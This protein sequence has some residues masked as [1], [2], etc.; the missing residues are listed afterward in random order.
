MRIGIDIDGV[1]TNIEQFIIDYLTRY[2]VLHHI[3]Y[4]IGEANYEED[5]AFGIS[6]EIKDHFWE[7]YLE[8]YAIHE[9]ARA[10]SSEVIQKLHE[11][12]NEIY[13][14]TARSLS[15]R[16][17]SIGKHMRNLVKEWLKRNN[18][19]YDQLIF[20]KASDEN[21]LDE[22]LEYKID[23][24]IEDN[25]SNIEN[26]SKYIPIICYDADY[27]RHCNGLNIIRSYSWYDI[28]KKIH[29]MVK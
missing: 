27:N 5:I 20:S 3:E 15:S 18:I 7:D 22:I 13:I 19:F 6:K 16:N 8:Y 24:M 26:L 1:L 17:D 9:P 12:G 23:I 10:F 11:E 25:P 14:I 2:C 21:K 28:Y 4:S 29:E